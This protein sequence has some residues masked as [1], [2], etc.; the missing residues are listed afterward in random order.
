MESGGEE[1]VFIYGWWVICGWEYG[2]YLVY[3]DFGLCA[4]WCLVYNSLL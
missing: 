1:W 2:V 3:S 4:V